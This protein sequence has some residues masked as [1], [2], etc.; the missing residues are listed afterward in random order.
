MLKSSLFHANHNCNERF[1]QLTVTKHEYLPKQFNHNR[2][3]H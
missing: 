1:C 2:I 3:H